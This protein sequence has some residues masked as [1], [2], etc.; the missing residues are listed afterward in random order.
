MGKGPDGLL[1]CAGCRDGLDF[2]FTMAFQPILHLSKQEVFAHEALVRGLGGEGAGS[3]LAQV[4][5]RNRFAFDQHCRVKAVELASA[6][7]LPGRVSINFLPNAVY[8]PVH[9]LRTTIQAARGA[10]MP[11]DRIILEVTEGERIADPQH[12]KRILD[13]YK[14]SGLLTAIDDFGAG[15]AGLNL[16]AEY[17]PDIIKLDMDLV[18]GIDANATR[19][20][21]VSGIL[22]VCHALSITVVAEGIETEAEMTTLR[23][24]GVD[25][26]QGFLFARPQLGAMPQVRWP[27]ALARPAIPALHANAVPD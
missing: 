18:R 2:D 10:G 6:L 12:L 15:Y 4:T 16:L 1:G 13:A 11:L 14:R 23:D 25:L 19:K 20:A 8:E 7:R 3:I 21:I 5:D 17:Q 9:C 26:M 24:M 27:D 22:G